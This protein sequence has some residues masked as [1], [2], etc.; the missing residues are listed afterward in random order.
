MS[1]VKLLKLNLAV[2]NRRPEHDCFGCAIAPGKSGQLAPERCSHAIRLG[3]IS[4]KSE[5]GG[6]KQT[7]NAI[8]EPECIRCLPQR[9]VAG[10]ACNLPVGMLRTP[11][12]R[13]IASDFPSEN[14]NF[15]LQPHTLLAEAR[16]VRCGGLKVEA[17]AQ[18]ESAERQTIGFP[19]SCT[20]Q[21]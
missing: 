4:T 17:T 21:L 1:N 9:N 11:F 14:V 6:V 10:A 5:V 8:G 7:I 3:E 20:A 18:S 19:V 16:E 12:I 15:E 13:D 2:V